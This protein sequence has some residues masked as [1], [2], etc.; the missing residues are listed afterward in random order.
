[1]KREPGNPGRE[2]KLSEKEAHRLLARAVELDAE[3]ETVISL[4]D[5]REAAGEAGIAR[6]AFEQALVEFRAGEL[7]PLTVGQ[8]LSM[9]LAALRRVGAVLSFVSAAAVTPGDSLVWSF[10]GGLGLYGAYEGAIALARLLGR[11]APPRV[12]P[13]AAGI[14]TLRRRERLENLP[15]DEQGPRFVVLARR[16]FDGPDHSTA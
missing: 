11:N 14:G 2:P 16:L 3:Q 12:P 9:K 13:G 8:Q 15:E 6:D 5:L 7:E 10:V 4:S 1:M